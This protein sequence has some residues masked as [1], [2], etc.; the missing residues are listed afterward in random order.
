MLAILSGRGLVGT[1]R[2]AQELLAEAIREV[3]P[4]AGEWTV[5]ELT[6]LPV[7]VDADRVVMASLAPHERTARIAKYRTVRCDYTAEPEGWKCYPEL[8]GV[9]MDIQPLPDAATCASPIRGVLNPSGLAD[10]ELLQAVDAVRHGDE[11]ENDFAAMCGA[12]WRPPS[13]PFESFRCGVRAVRARDDGLL[14][15]SVAAGAGCSTIISLESVCPYRGLLQAE[16]GEMCTGMFLRCSNALTSSPQR[17]RSLRSERC[18]PR[19]RWQ[20]RLR[21][22]GR[23]RV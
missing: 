5:E 13:V 6:G 1:S 16:A 23:L 18:P 15:V 21:R 9:R 2:Q 22:F 12:A 11:F 17:D 4:D 8:A 3:Y 7:L 20:G 14:T 19:L 10:A